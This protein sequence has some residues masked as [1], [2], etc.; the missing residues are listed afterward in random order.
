[1]LYNRR[2]AVSRF[3]FYA[4]RTWAG[5]A[6]GFLPFCLQSYPNL[7]TGLSM[8]IVVAIVIESVYK[9]GEKWKLYSKASD[10]LTVAELQSKGQYENAKAMMDIIIA[11]EGQ[12]LENLVGL[13]DLLQKVKK[14]GT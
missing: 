4:S 7:A 9:P 6:A 12:A 10:L 3:A 1:M 5:L 14:A 11:T 13:D 2:A 8:S